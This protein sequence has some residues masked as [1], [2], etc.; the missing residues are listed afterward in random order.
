MIIIINATDKAKQTLRRI[1][2]DNVVWP[3]AI[4]RLIDRGR[5]T[6]VMGVYMETPVQCA[7]FPILI[8]AP[9]LAAGRKQV[10]LD[11]KDTTEESDLA[12][13][14]QKPC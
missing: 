13:F 7:G 10:T 2:E 3:V 5:G 14:E 4:L 8:V 11:V 6:L 1:F 9:D 12:T